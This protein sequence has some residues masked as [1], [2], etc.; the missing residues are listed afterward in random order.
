MDTRMRTRMG[1]CMEFPS[2]PTTTPCERAFCALCVV[3]RHV[4][5]QAWVRGDHHDMQLTLGR[6]FSMLHTMPHAAP[7]AV[8]TPHTVGSSHSGQ[9]GLSS[10]LAAQ[11]QQQ[12]SRHD[13]FDP[14]TGLG[15]RAGTKTVEVSRKFWVR[16]EDVAEVYYTVLQ[17]LPLVETPKQ[18]EAA[19]QSA[20]PPARPAPRT[21]S[22]MSVPAS[23]SGPLP[24][25]RVPGTDSGGW[26]AGGRSPLSG[27][28]PVRG[29]ALAVNPSMEAPPHALGHSRSMGRASGSQGGA[30]HASSPG[31]SGGLMAWG[32]RGGSGAAAE[33]DEEDED[34]VNLLYLDNGALELY[35]NLLYGRPYASLVR[36]RW[37]GDGRPQDGEVVV[38][39]KVYQEG[40]RPE[41]ATKDSFPVP[42]NRVAEFLAGRWTFADAAKYLQRHQHHHQQWRQHP[43]T[44]DWV[45]QGGT[46][47]GR[48]VCVCGR[49]EGVGWGVGNVQKLCC[50]SAPLTAQHVWGRTRALGA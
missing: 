15:A 19:P 32:A 50:K 18:S 41:T 9:G 14:A 8:N 4:S 34:T 16:A 38:Q 40:W 20:S 44:L 27:T 36:L 13:A 3:Q 6:I 26:G 45:G 24:H 23:S 49:G 43:H 46:G 39:R 1:T 30:R 21:P 42:D 47:G 22:R 10:A 25:L 12:H 28:S 29:P 48:Q 31:A 5:G 35:H 33:E 17:H 2:P 11:Q 37:V 7:P